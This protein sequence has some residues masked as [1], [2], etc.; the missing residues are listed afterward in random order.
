[1]K[2]PQPEEGLIIDA[3]E[4][5]GKVEKTKLVSSTTFVIPHNANI[6]SDD[7]A[8]KVSIGVIN[9]KPDFEYESVPRKSP[10]VFIRAKVKN[11]SN[12][13]ILP[14]LANVFFDNN[15]VAKVV[16]LFYFKS[17]LFIRFLNLC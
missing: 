2:P 14:G 1:M 9:L 17:V 6:P 4:T 11:D 7:K 5:S 16:F 3:T 13:L 8:H 10:N 15:L 12:Y